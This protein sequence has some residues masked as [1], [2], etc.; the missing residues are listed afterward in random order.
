MC[1]PFAEHR[2]RWLT[3][4]GI[5]L[6]TGR[7]IYHLISAH[8]CQNRYISFPCRRIW[9]VSALAAIPISSS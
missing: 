3:I 8:G 7:Q 6:K 9:T 2:V 5:L 4:T 1:L